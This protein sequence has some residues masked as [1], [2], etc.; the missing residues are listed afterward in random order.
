MSPSTR[1]VT[2]TDDR[3]RPKAEWKPEPV[4]AAPYAFMEP[5]VASPI[6][7]RK[8]TPEELAAARAREDEPQHL[9]TD[10]RRTAPMGALPAPA[11]PPM[12]NEGLRAV[13]ER[14]PASTPVPEPPPAIQEEPPVSEVPANI[15]EI[16]PS[17]DV[18]ALAAA[19]GDGEWSAIGILADAVLEMIE[20]DTERA[21]AATRWINARAALDAAYKGLDSPPALYAAPISGS[22]SSADRTSIE[23]VSIDRSKSRAGEGQRPGQLAARERRAAAVMAALERHGGD[24]KAAAAELG[25]KTNAIAMVV[26]HARRRTEASA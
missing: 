9:T 3:G 23:P 10:N 6:E 13:F 11:R 24:Q 22:A 18:E 16:I 12:R 1:V 17:V 5:A 19:R 20:A 7:T 26:K 2:G 21:M 25:M 15:P 8:A 4:A 14:H